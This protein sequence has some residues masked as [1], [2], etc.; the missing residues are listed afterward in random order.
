MNKAITI[1]WT[2]YMERFA[3]TLAEQERALRAAGIDPD[4]ATWTA[5]DVERAAEVLNRG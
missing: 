2:E 5:A 1:T 3:P 4:P